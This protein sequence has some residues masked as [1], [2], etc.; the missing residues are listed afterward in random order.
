MSNGRGVSIKEIAA[1]AQGGAAY[2]P[3]QLEEDNAMVKLASDMQWAMM[4]GNA[5]NT[6][7][8]DATTEKGIYNA[9]AFDGF[10]GVT[11]SVGAF[12][13]NNAVQVDQGSLNILESIQNCAAT[14]AQ[15]GGRPSLAFLSI[16]SKQ[17]LDTEQQNNRVYMEQTT[18]II[19]GLSANQIVFANGKIVL[20]PV[21]GSSIGTYLRTS[22]SKSVEDIYVL[23][24]RGIWIRW[25]YSESWTV[26]QIPSGVDG[27]LSDR[28]IIFGMMGLQQAMPI[29]S[30][31]VRRT[32]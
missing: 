25:L 24:E 17:L 18:D 27:K 8:A 16:N 23:D 9:L 2:N 7:S 30:G 13:A 1:V 3:R 31:K 15:N 22:D 11:G 21:P 12:S 26:L 19:P 6:P 32:V 4:Q 28:I 20:C 10:R 29:Y 14:Q 5:T